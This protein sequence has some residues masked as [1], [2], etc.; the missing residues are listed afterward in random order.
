MERGRT[1]PRSAGRWRSGPALDDAPP[2]PRLLAHFDPLLMGYRDRALILDP[3]DA[4]HIQAGGGSSGAPAPAVSCVPAGPLP[5]AVTATVPGAIR[6]QARRVSAA[7]SP[8]QAAKSA[9]PA[10][11]YPLR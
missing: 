6:S 2:L 7:G 3:G 1:S 8:D 5:D 10:G 11:P 9:R 4:A